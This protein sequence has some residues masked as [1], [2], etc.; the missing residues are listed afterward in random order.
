MI[1]LNRGLKGFPISFNKHTQNILNKVTPTHISKTESVSR[2]HWMWPVMYYTTTMSTYRCT[3]TTK[4]SEKDI[5]LVILTSHPPT[6]VFIIYQLNGT[7]VWQIQKVT[8]LLLD[9]HHFLTL[10]IP[11]SN[12]FIVVGKLIAKNWNCSDVQETIINTASCQWCLLYSRQNYCVT[13]PVCPI[14]PLLMD[15]AH[16]PQ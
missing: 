16:F 8:D 4:T 14:G 10:I 9:L 2:G 15:A 3:H 13:A 6:C 1:Y 11:M 5:L 7:K 12:Y